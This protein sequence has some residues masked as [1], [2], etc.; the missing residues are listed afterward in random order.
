MSASRRL[1]AVAL[2]GVAA[3]LA[4]LVPHA[5]RADSANRECDNNNDIT[6]VVDFQELI[7]GN[8]NDVN[9][10]CAPQPV[11]SGFDALQRANI[12]YTTYRG[13]VCRIAG[14]PSADDEPCNRYPP[15][16][17]Y[18]VYWYAERGG[19]WTYSQYGAADR[20]PPPGSIEGWSFAK[21]RDSGSLPPPRYPVPKPIP[22][23]ATTTSAAPSGNDV[24]VAPS[25][26]TR[27]TR[28]PRTS[29]TTAAVPSATP[30]LVTTTTTVVALA[31]PSTPT[32]IALG[33]VDLSRGSGGGSP[34]G[35]VIGIG[36]LIVLAGAAVVLANRRV[37]S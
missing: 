4:L 11:N 22:S 26:T 36:A 29:S 32:S 34:L 31:D 28:A 2:A 20:T 1:G 8:N 12:N 35:F 18:W 7:D 19:G 25:A 23:A 16:N 15:A 30:T 24:S 27:V 33:H 14:L 10:R 5:A 37:G 6:V 21:N 13:F 3:T 9:V 17:A